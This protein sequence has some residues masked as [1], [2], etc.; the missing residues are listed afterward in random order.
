MGAK[1]KADRKEII[2][3]L[4]SKSGDM[5]ME[6]AQKQRDGKEVNEALLAIL[7]KGA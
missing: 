7:P 3:T 1:I 5:F 4:A 6:M 2:V